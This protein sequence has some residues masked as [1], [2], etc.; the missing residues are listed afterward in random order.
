MTANAT[1][2]Q[3]NAVGFRTPQPGSQAIFGLLWELHPLMCSALIQIKK[4]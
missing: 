3:Q 1:Y 2:R 4:R